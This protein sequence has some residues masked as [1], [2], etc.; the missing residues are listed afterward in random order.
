MKKVFRNLALS[1]AIFAAGVSVVGCGDK[2]SEPQ[3]STTE[4]TTETT[5][6]TTDIP[7]TTETT[8][9]IPTSTT[10][11]PKDC[12]DDITKTLKL[13]K[14]YNSSSAFFVDGIEEVRLV[15]ATDGDTAGFV[16]KNSGEGVT[17]RFYDV[18]TPEST[19]S[20]EKWG[21]SASLFTKGKLENAAAL[22]LEGSQ[23]PPVVDSYGSR[24]LAY[25]WYKE[26]ADSEWKNLN[27]EIVENGFSAAKTLPSDPYESYFE[28]AQTFAKRVPL[29]I[30]SDDADPY[31]SEDASN[32]TVKELSDNFSEYYDAENEIGQ[33]VRFDGYVSNVSVSSSQAY[34]YKVSAVED[35]K[36]Y[37]IDVYAGYNSTGIPDFFKIGNLYQITGTVQKHSGRFQVSGL[38]YVPLQ[39]GGDYL[40]RLVR[41]YYMQ[42]NSSVAFKN[43]IDKKALYRDAVVTAAKVEN[44][45]LVITAK[46]VNTELYEKDNS[47]A[48]EE[49]TFYC[50]VEDGFNA[51][52][53]VN[54][55]F[56]VN[57]YQEEGKDSN[58]IFVLHYSDF[59]FK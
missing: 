50:E 12:Y 49:F 48:A 43:T 20:V 24:Y 23:T 11:V 53:L 39:E 1:A 16:G 59:N 6:A 13:T 10:F 52:A 21:K 45:Q 57:G 32:V 22:L 18:D 40:T 9:E 27:L 55:V 15:T 41:C 37:T 56:S 38:T 14:S 5:T 36:V 46:A 35:G 29:H 34:T 33:K 19:G 51:T 31:F 17:I 7:T 44:G 4:T 8:T 58:K 42:F 47:T 30:W 54:K 25:V 2:P 28:A 3:I 26:T